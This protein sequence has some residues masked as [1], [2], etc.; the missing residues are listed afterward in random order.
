MQIFGSQYPVRRHHPFD[1][2]ACDPARLDRG[3]IRRTGRT[4]I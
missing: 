4:L 2:R 1:A 3:E